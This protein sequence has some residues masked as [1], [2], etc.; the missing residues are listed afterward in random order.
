PP[1][2]SEYKDANS[3]QTAPIIAESPSSKT[4]GRSKS[5]LPQDAYGAND[6]LTELRPSAKRKNERENERQE[7]IAPTYND[8]TR[9]HDIVTADLCQGGILSQ[10]LPGY[11]ERP[12]QIEMATLVARSLTQNV[13]AITEAGTGTGKSLAYLV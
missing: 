4:N 8:E 13:P 7:D 3:K 6:V 9:L 2:H 10:R 1:D 11:E 5:K 12:A